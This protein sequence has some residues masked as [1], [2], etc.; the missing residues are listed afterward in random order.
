MNSLIACAERH[1]SSSPPTICNEGQGSCHFDPGCCTTNRI[2]RDYR[3]GSH[4]NSS[5]ARS[6]TPLAAGSVPQS[7]VSVEESVESEESEP[8]S[9]LE[10]EGSVKAGSGS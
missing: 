4:H 1:S 10:P 9:V 3:R 5:R 6:S 7:A 8:A 2:Q